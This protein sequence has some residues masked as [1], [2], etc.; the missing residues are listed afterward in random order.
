MFKYL[1]KKDTIF[2]TLS[3][4]LVM[5]LLSFIPLNTHVLDPL[6]LALQ[7]FDYNDMAYSRLGKNN[8]IPIDTSIVVVNIEDADRLAIANMIKKVSAC[9][10]KVIGVDVLFNE[11][12]DSVADSM[13]RTAFAA[14]P[15]IVMAYNL[16]EVDHHLSHDG[17]FF[18]Q[19]K[20]KG[21]VNFVGEEGGVNRSVQSVLQDHDNKYLPFAATIVKIVDTARFQQFINRN[22]ELETINY[23]RN[24]DKYIVIDG[25]SL[26]TNKVD[27]SVLLNKIVLLG[28]VSKSDQDVQDKHF[29]PLNTRFIGKSIPDL[30]GVFIHANIINML[31]E[32]SYIKQSP[33]W[34][35]WVIALVLC[36]LHMAFFIKYFLDKHI[37]FH[38]A[39]KVAQLLSAIFFVYLGLR[40]FYGSNMQIN[41]TIT[42]TA[43]VV[44][45]DVLYLYEALCKWLYKKYRYES[46]FSLT[47][48]H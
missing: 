4:F 3:V 24:A 42:L 5:G 30:N 2:A 46:L 9:S 31:Q 12:K 10:P 37:W 35:N 18:E 8:D 13:L 45:V 29:T 36:W 39:A 40:L 48:H 25:H 38:L 32:G 47:S 20:N 22:K 43:I 28:Y 23:S 14:D 7:D 21:F 41:M 33:K 16:Q 27:T 15:K 34:L 26:F 11:K 44:A 1:F 6:K 17:Y 19:A